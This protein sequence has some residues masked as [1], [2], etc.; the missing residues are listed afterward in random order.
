MTYKKKAIIMGVN[1]RNQEDNFEYLME[2]LKGLVIA[3]NMEV[4][5]EV[6]QNLDHINHSHYI[7][8]GKIAELDGL[9]DFTK[10][11]RAHV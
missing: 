1:Y 10:I 7:G 11:G 2:E 4:V 5:G 9:L 6:S 3:C 8:S